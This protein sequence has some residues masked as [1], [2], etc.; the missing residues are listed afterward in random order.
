[1][2][3]L[4]GLASIRQAYTGPEIEELAYAAGFDDFEV[5]RIAPFRLGLI[6]WTFMTTSLDRAPVAYSL[7][8]LKTARAVLVEQGQE[9]S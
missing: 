4:D 3:R 2:S 6:L 1:M 7:K 9:T 8:A 5:H